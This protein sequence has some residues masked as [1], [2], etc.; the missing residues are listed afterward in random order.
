MRQKSVL[1][2]G[3]SRYQLDAIHTARQLGYRIVCSDNVPA[4]PGHAL[5]DRSHFIDTTDKERILALAQAEQVCGVMSPCTDVAVPTAAFVAQRMGLVGPPPS[6]A[7]IL[8]DKLAFRQF[9]DAHGLPVPRFFPLPDTEVD[10]SMFRGQAWIVKPDRSSGSKGVFILDSR[11]MLDARLAETIAFSPNRRAILEQ[12][13]EGFQGT[14]EGIVRGG[15]LVLS[16]FLDRKTVAS[17]FAT[18]CGH[19]LPT[20]LP[21]STQRRITQKLEAIWGL[22]NVRETVFDCD[23]VVAGEDI[24]ILEMS[25]RLGGNCISSLLLRASGFNFVE[26]AIRL[27]CGEHPRAPTSLVLQPMAVMIFGP[28]RSGRAA[29]DQAALEQLRRCEWVASLTMDVDVG[30]VV[31]QFINGR[32]R[33]GECFVRGSSRED[34]SAKCAEVRQ[35]LQVSAT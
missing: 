26:Y 19:Q 24:Y 2:L 21:V 33:I 10:E 18:T 7:E 20:S 3:A 17:P 23:F 11:S 4:N 1:I 31:H 12:F 13:I 25:P 5:A 35:R 9:M 8:C 28:D 16:C 32:N 29:Y 14:C 15:K 34:V 6:A 30:D 22:L 27:A